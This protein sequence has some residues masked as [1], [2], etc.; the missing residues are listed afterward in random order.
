M[1]A[2]LFVVSVGLLL[3]ARVV[4]ERKRQLFAFLERP[5]IEAVHF[6]E[7]VW[8]VRVGQ[9]PEA[10]SWVLAAVAC[11]LFGGIG[12]LGLGLGLFVLVRSAPVLLLPTILFGY[13]ARVGWLGLSAQ[14]GRVPVVRRLR[15]TQPHLLLDEVRL[16]LDVQPED[17]ESAPSVGRVRAIPWTDVLRVDLDDAQNLVIGVRGDSDAVFGPLSETEAERLIGQIERGRAREVPDEAE[18]IDLARARLKALKE[19]ADRERPE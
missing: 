4:D 13:A 9:L 10:T 6:D 5:A 2:I 11:L 16:G 17:V 19:R 1:P 18:V 3:L 12:L 15:L 8:G 14:M 7:V